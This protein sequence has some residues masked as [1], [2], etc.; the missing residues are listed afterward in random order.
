MCEECELQYSSKTTQN[1]LL[2]SIKLYLQREIV[3]RVKHQKYNDLFLEFKLTTCLMC[4][5]KNNWDW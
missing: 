5:T 4:Q 1:E 3:K 2:D